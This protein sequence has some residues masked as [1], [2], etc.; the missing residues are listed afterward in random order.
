MRC[1]RF[2]CLAALAVALVSCSTAGSDSSEPKTLVLY[3]QPALDGVIDWI[4]PDIGDPSYGSLMTGDSAS[5]GDI[6]DDGGTSR[7]V[8]SFD[9][10]S[11]PEGASIQ[12]ATL[13]VRQNADAVGDPYAAIGAGGGLGEVLVDVIQ[14]TASSSLSDLF[15]QLVVVNGDNYGTLSPSFSADTW[16]ELDVTTIAE[17]VFSGLSYDSLQFRLYHESEQ[18]GDAVS[19]SDGWVMG[20]AA[21]YRPELV[22][23]YTE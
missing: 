14:Y 11:L 5:I 17:S 20:D 4:T 6:A 1:L 21:E 16:R 23:E 10:S 12:S 13:R 9:L 18:D 2:F 22:V 7:V 8:L 19:D 15:G 3:S